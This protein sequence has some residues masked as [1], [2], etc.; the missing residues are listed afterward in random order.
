MATSPRVIAQRLAALGA[1]P[2]EQR[3]AH[4]MERVEA[5]ERYLAANPDNT[6]AAEDFWFYNNIY[7]DLCLHCPVIAE[8]V[9]QSRANVQAVML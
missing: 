8:Q 1:M 7:L 4:L 3:L 6:G 9:Y 5:G 2:V